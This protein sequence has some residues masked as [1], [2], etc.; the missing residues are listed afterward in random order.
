M[1]TS[2][3][4]G[5]FTRKNLETIRES[6]RVIEQ[7]RAARRVQRSAVAWRNIGL[8][9]YDNIFL[10]GEESLRIA[11]SWHQMHHMLADSGLA[12]FRL[13][14]CIAISTFFAISDGLGRLTVHAPMILVAET[15]LVA[16]G[17]RSR[18]ARTILR[19]VLEVAII[20]AR[21]KAPLLVVETLAS[22]H[23]TESR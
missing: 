17:N 6:T 13:A 7:T 4:D 19:V 21:A 8:A 1:R 20:S 18:V 3:D 5:D 22:L 2:G 10:V 12:T 11:F 14:L 15:A 16:I 9:S 23:R